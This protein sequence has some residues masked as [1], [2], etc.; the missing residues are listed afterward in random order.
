LRDCILLATEG[1][2]VTWAA[3]LNV[4]VVG[5]LAAAVSWA[6]QSLELEW[7][8]VWVGTAALLLG[9]DTLLDRAVSNSV[10]AAEAVFEAWVELD[11]GKEGSEHLHDEEV[12]DDAGPSR[13]VVVSVGSGAR[14]SESVGVVVVLWVVGEKSESGS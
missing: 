11:A 5:L 3:L 12:L 7:K 13:A 9:L 10:P 4:W 8:S 14:F 6:A 1:D 2:S